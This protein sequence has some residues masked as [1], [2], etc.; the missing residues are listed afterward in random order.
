MDTPGLGTAIEK[1]TKAVGI[2]PCG[3]CQKRKEM[4][5]RLVPPRKKESK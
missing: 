4:L 1:L 2:K 5:D 3:G